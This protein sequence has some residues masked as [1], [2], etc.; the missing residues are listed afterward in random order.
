MEI[1]GTVVSLQEN[2]ATVSVRR[3][4]ACG[5]NC[6]HCKGACESTATVA[7]AENTAGAE[8]GDMVKIESDSGAV[9]KAAVVLYIVPV[10]VTI[11]AAVALYSAGI[12]GVLSGV[13]SAVA[14]FASFFVIKRFE[15]RLTPKLYITKIIRG[16]K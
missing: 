2:I 5:E 4:S 8:V 12:G 3:V 6:A 7:E 9:I 11:V 1:V 14:F 10:L 13:A 16:T 15:K